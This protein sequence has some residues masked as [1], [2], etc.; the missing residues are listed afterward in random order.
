[1][2]GL[3]TSVRLTV[4]LKVAVGLVASIRR[5]V[6]LDFYPCRS[7]FDGGCWG[8]HRYS[9]SCGAHGL[10]VYGSAMLPRRVGNSDSGLGAL[11]RSEANAKHEA[12]GSK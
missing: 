12:Y 9:V 1:M 5:A 11:R 8:V 6:C 7:A 10:G 4:F 2:V 3:I